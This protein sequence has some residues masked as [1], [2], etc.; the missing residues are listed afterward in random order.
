MNRTLTACLLAGVFVLPA[1]APDTR[2]HA[3]G[4]HSFAQTAKARNRH[5]DWTADNCK[6]LTASAP[7]CG[8]F[9][10]QFRVRRQVLAPDPRS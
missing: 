6:A 8:A 1:F 4:A 5:C 7:H 9:S 10:H 2:F 3:I